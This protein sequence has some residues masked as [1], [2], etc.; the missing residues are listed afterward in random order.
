MRLKIMRCNIILVFSRN[1]IMNRNGR[2]QLEGYW[3]VQVSWAWSQIVI[4]AV[5]KKKWG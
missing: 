3:G 2:D 4:A 5:A 1:E